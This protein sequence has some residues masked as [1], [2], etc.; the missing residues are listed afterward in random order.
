[1]TAAQ[2]GVIYAYAN[3]GSESPDAPD[4]VIHTY[5]NVGLDDTD[6]PGEY[7]GVIHTYGNVGLDDTDAPGEYDAV[8]YTYTS[9]GAFPEGTAIA[10]AYANVLPV[11]IVKVWDGEGWQIATTR[12]WTGTEFV[13]VEYGTWM[14]DHWEDH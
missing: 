5:G 6:A 10:F 2:D 12:Q 8:V 9:V 13:G 4:G 1:M 11:G 14:S 3:V 7:D